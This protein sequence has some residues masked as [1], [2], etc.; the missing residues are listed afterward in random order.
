MCQLPEIGL[1]ALLALIHDSDMD[2]RRVIKIRTQTHC[3]AYQD[4]GSIGGNI[5]LSRT[6]FRNVSEPAPHQ[7]AANG[8]SVE[9]A[10]D[11]LLSGG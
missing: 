5:A 3:P 9:I 1:S 10:V 7:V 11:V 2:F 4:E 6:K 8:K